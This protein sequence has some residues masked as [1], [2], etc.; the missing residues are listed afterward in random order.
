MENCKAYNLIAI[1]IPLEEISWVDE[2]EIYWRGD[3]YDIKEIQISDGKLKAFAYPDN[4]EEALNEDYKKNNPAGQSSSQKPKTTE[5]FLK[6][7]IACEVRFTASNLNFEVVD[8]NAIRGY[9]IPFFP[10]PEA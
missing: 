3:I 7:S 4:E 10:P 6:S 2:H 8:L 5:S 9:K 1:E